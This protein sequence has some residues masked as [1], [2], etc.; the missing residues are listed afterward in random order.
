MFKLKSRFVKF[1][2]PLEFLRLVAIFTLM[3]LNNNLHGLEEAFW[4]WNTTSKRQFHQRLFWGKKKHSVKSL[5]SAKLH[6]VNSRCRSKMTLVYLTY[7]IVNM[8]SKLIEPCRKRN[9]AR[10]EYLLEIKTYYLLPTSNIWN[11]NCIT[12]TKILC[13][14]VVHLSKNSILHTF[15]HLVSFVLH[16]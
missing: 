3:L 9:I 4:V 15:T 2:L 14:E 16:H 13:Y 11:W 1:W 5:N 12:Y 8:I 7:K 10:L 6:C